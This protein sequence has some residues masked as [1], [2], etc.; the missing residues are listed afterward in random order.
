[1][2]PMHWKF[3]TADGMAV[4]VDGAEAGEVGGGVP[5]H[6]PELRSV[7]QSLRPTMVAGTTVAGTIRTIMRGPNLTTTHIPIITPAITA[8]TDI[9]FIGR[10]RITI[11][12]IMDGTART[13]IGDEWTKA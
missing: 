6:S 9:T 4:G 13:I 5:E 7:Q 11:G 10:S 12:I 3:A 2:V 1:M 8:L